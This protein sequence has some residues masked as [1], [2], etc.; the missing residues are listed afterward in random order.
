MKPSDKQ[1]FYNDLK[2]D[3]AQKATLISNLG[4]FFFIVLCLLDIYRFINHMEYSLIDRLMLCSHLIMFFFCIPILNKKYSFIPEFKNKT[5][6]DINS[7]IGFILI[8][9]ALLPMA[10]FSIFTRGDLIVF[11]IF[12]TIINLMFETKTAS[13]IR[14]NIL[15]FFVITIALYY[16]TR[17][18]VDFVTKITSVLGVVIP[19]YIISALQY[20][21]RK[22]EFKN[23]L[24]LE[25]KNLLLE[26]KNKTISKKNEELKEFAYAA[27]HDLKEPLRMVGTFTGLIK[28]KLD[29]N[30]D[31]RVIEYMGFVTQGVNNMEQML[32]DLLDYATLENHEQDYEELEL[33]MILL[34]VLNNLSPKIQETKAQIHLPQN[35]ITINAPKTYLIQLIQNLVSNGIKFTPSERVPEINILINQTADNT[36]ISIKDNGIGI[37]EEKQDFVFKIFKRL[38]A[39]SEY[40]GHGIGLAT[41]TKIMEKLG[42]KISL[43]SEH[44]KGTTFHLSFP[45]IKA[46]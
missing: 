40:E 13:K 36:I 7:L 16:G 15:A 25:E 4:F 38:H 9:A 41:C 5:V 17:D 42:G 21:L 1:L 30:L 3:N 46:A 18:S 24:L 35:P 11:G 2:R 43:E 19:T 34:R 37:P 14:M 22:K 29:G 10:V 12:M 20:G 27:S 33:N 32:R 44:G 6:F 28:K 45:N 8:W 39:K 31:N 23:R 26:E